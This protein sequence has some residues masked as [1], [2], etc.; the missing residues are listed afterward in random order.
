MKREKRSK[1]VEEGAKPVRIQVRV[2][3]EE[4]G[5]MGRVDLKSGKRIRKTRGSKERFRMEMIEF[6]KEKSFRKPSRS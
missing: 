3:A 5:D 1:N 2:G 4:R 6:A